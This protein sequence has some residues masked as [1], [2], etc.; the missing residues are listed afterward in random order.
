MRATTVSATTPPHEGVLM[1][2]PVSSGST[3]R[4]ANISPRFKALA[5]QSQRTQYL[6]PWLDQIQVSRSFG[7]EQELPSGVGQRKEHRV[8]APVHPQVVHN[9]HHLAYCWL[10]R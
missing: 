6:P 2:I 9:R 3:H 7:L 4:T 5:F 10:K 8:H 1:S